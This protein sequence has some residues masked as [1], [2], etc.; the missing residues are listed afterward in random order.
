MP[1]SGYLVIEMQCLSC[2]DSRIKVPDNAND[3]SQILCGYCRHDLGPYG[4]LKAQLRGDGAGTVANAGASDV[5]FKPLKAEPHQTISAPAEIE[6]LSDGGARV[7]FF[8]SSHGHTY[9]QMAPEYLQRLHEDI[10]QKI[11]AQNP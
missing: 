3:E 10:A 1:V 2:G 4:V 7:Q 8:S 11:A 9:V 5:K 6:L